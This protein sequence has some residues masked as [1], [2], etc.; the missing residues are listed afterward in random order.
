M[1]GAVLEFYGSS[2]SGVGTRNCRIEAYLVSLKFEGYI[3]TISSYATAYLESGLRKKFSPILCFYVLKKTNSFVCLFVLVC[4]FVT[5]NK[6]HA[7]F[8]D[9]I[10]TT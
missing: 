5:Q 6:N 8:Q 3:G 1:V 10:I 9:S 2:D 4:L 7:T